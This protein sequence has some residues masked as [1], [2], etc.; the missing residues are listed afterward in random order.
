MD[1]SVNTHI[2]STCGVIYDQ[3]GRHRATA[4]LFL[5]SSLLQVGDGEAEST[6]APQRDSRSSK[7]SFPAMRLVVARPS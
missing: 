5:G 3:Q 1:Q 6:G 2:C 4:F 7:R